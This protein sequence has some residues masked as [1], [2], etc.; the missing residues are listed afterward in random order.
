MPFSSENFKIQGM[1]NRNI[2]DVAPQIYKEL[3]KELEKID[4]TVEIGVSYGVGDSIEMLTK[5][6]GKSG[7]NYVRHE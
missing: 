6:T 5:L 2:K 3:C 7:V 1:V 4:A